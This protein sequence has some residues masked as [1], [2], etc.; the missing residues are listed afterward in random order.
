MNKMKRKLNTKMMKR[1]KRKVLLLKRIRIIQKPSLLIT[2]D[3][4]LAISHFCDLDQ[5]IYDL[6]LSLAL[7]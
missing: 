6:A 5:V 1:M 2:S 4:F 7:H 3:S